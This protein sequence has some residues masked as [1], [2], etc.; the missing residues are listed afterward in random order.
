[1]RQQVRPWP[2]GIG[3]LALLAL[4]PTAYGSTTFDLRLEVATEQKRVEQTRPSALG[5]TLVLNSM[6]EQQRQQMADSLAKLAVAANKKKNPFFVSLDDSEAR[7]AAE[8]LIKQT[9]PGFTAA[10]ALCAGRWQSREGDMHIRMVSRC[11]A[12]TRCI[13]LTEPP[14]GDEAERRA[15]FLAWPLGYAI[16]LEVAPGT[17][18][19]QV[20]QS[21]RGPGET[22]IA[23]VLTSDELHSLRESPALTKLLKRVRQIA[24]IVPARGTPLRAVVARIAIAATA[25]DELPWLQLPAGA[26]LVVPRLGSLATSDAFVAEAR[27]RLGPSAARVKWIAWPR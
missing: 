8:D 24:K 18:V 20:A 3:W 14:S 7:T 25:G 22:H 21:L 2:A 5:T 4:A 6:G 12:K 15:R 17:D 27:T 23:L 1:M 19:N 11:A 26:I 13:S 10:S 9:A 16:L